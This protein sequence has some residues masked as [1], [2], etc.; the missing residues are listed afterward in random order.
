MKVSGL[1]R[2]VSPSITHHANNLVMIYRKILYRLGFDFLQ[3]YT[4]GILEFISNEHAG[5]IPRAV[6]QIFHHVLERSNTHEINISLSFLQLYRETI[7]DLLAP[8]NGSAP[9]GDDNLMIR[10]DPQRGFYVEG[11]QEFAVRSYREAGKSR[12]CFPSACLVCAKCFASFKIV[13]C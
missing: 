13:L 6:A 3:T 12:L 2:I 7:Q 4:M 5:I 8:A 11:L 1:G 10:E 9:S